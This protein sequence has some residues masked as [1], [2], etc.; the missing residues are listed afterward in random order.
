M[1]DQLK[2]MMNA[3][4]HEEVSTILRAIIK[5]LPL[6]VENPYNKGR[7]GTCPV[8]DTY[9]HIDEHYCKNCGQRLSFEGLEDVE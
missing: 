1:S 6:T 2:Q 7:Y 5:S 3:L 9:V 8:C 4:S